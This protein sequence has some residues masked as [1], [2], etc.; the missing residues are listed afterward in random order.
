MRHGKFLKCLHVHLTPRSVHVSGEIAKQIR[1]LKTV[2]ISISKD[3]TGIKSSQIYKKQKS[4]HANW[5]SSRITF[6]NQVFLHV[7]R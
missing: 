6:I 4:V 7:S 2:P 5:C 1:G 3:K